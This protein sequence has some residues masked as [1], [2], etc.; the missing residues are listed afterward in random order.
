MASIADFIPVYDPFDNP[1]IQ[2]IISGKRE[3]QD[4]KLKMRELDPVPGGKYLHQEQ[5]LR[6]MRATDRM[7]NI[8]E[9]GT[10]KSCLMAGV[11]EFFR[12]SGQFKKVIILESGQSTSSEIV[13]QIAFRCTNGEYIPED[14]RKQMDQTLFFKRVRK[15]V[16]QWYSIHNYMAFSQ[17]LSRLTDEEIVN[18]Y[19]HTLIFLDEVH[20]IT[21]FTGSDASMYKNIH[22]LLHLV[23]GC[24]IVLLTATPMVNSVDQIAPLMNLILPIDNQMPT[25]M[26]YGNVSFEYMEPFFRGRISYTRT[27]QGNAI[28]RYNGVKTET[29]LDDGTLAQTI[30]YTVEM[31]DFQSGMY[32]SMV[33]FNDS[34]HRD[35]KIYSTFPRPEFYDG[36]LINKSERIPEWGE[37]NVEKW[38]R[39]EHRGDHSDF[40]SWLKMDGRNTENLHKW[41]CKFARLIDL[42]AIG[43]GCSF[44]Y[45]DMIVDAG[46]DLLAKVMELF[47]YNVLW[48]GTVG[49]NTDINVWSKRPRVLVYTGEGDPKNNAAALGVFNHPN[50]VTG[51]YIKCLIGSRVARDGINIYHCRRVHV[52]YPHWHHSGGIQAIGRTL[53]LNSHV[54]L[55]R[56]VEKDRESTLRFNEGA[57]FDRVMVVDVYRYAA[58][59][60]KLQSVD[61]KIYRDADTKEFH[62]R[63]IYR[64]MKMA[65]VN[66]NLN[67]ERNRHAGDVDGSVEC[68][69]KRCNYSCYKNIPDEEADESTFKGMYRVSTI[70]KIA[71]ELQLMLRR[72][73]VIDI[74][75][76]ELDPE[77]VLSAVRY[78]QSQN[79][80]VKD[81]FGISKYVQTNGSLIFLQRQFPSKFIA[82]RVT[83]M[84]IYNRRL[85]AVHVQN[86]D[87]LLDERVEPEIRVTSRKRQINGTNK[88]ATVRLLHEAI[89]RHKSSV[90]TSDDSF[91][92]LAGKLFNA[93]RGNRS[94]QDLF[95]R[96]RHYIFFIDGVWVTTASSRFSEGG[97]WSLVPSF[98]SMPRGEMRTDE[99]WVN[100]S[101]DILEKVQHKIQDHLKTFEMKG[102]YGL[103]FDNEILRVRD[104]RKSG[105]ADHRK[106]FRGKAINTIDRHQLIDIYLHLHEMMTSTYLS[107]SNMKDLRE[108]PLTDLV[109]LVGGT[110]DEMGLIFNV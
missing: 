82:N 85:T 9:P 97:N 32:E 70:K 54:D 17:S 7:L 38:K 56:Y 8:D 28:P 102:V 93:A 39:W 13:K 76:S 43:F 86:D 110:M 1:E 25:E 27:M 96:F 99:N 24:K 18:E 16:G 92:E 79:K 48:P 34:F 103:Q 55:L 59:P 67:S 94:D 100:V 21:N 14:G 44:I 107:S 83:D 61:L 80:T 89:D 74:I 12:F 64:M 105:G 26:D 29:S 40:P 90:D 46:T 106:I 58:M 49:E 98:I 77:L 66:C 35:G 81:K 104:V 22:R 108:K 91:P 88:E 20:S 53:R 78:L 30:V 65:A 2:S 36:G 68:D 62:I 10:G 71:D 109:S 23:R 3:F 47:G 75:L 31:S 52:I 4:T 95:I 33:D 5:F 63:K 87:T 57:V 60:K 45:I 42:E 73:P 50:N 72:H 6:L 15:L 84:S 11:A 69:F 41:S 37:M 51:E 19:S 101:R